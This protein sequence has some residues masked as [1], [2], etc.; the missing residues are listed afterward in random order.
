MGIIIKCEHDAEEIKKARRIL[1]DFGI[2]SYEEHN[3]EEYI[4]IE[5]LVEDEGLNN[6]LSSKYFGNDGF[7]KTD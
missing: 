3:Y 2:I 4:G 7:I 5:V 6:F 1:C